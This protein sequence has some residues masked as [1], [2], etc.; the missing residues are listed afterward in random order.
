MVDT[1]SITTHVDPEI[2]VSSEPIADKNS[3]METKIKQL[4]NL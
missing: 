4:H 2:T 1:S 3:A